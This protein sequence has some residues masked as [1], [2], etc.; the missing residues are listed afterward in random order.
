M[1]YLKD[2]SLYKKQNVFYTDPISGKFNN[3]R[4]ITMFSVALSFFVLPWISWKGKQAFIF[5]IVYN[6]LYILNLT[7]WPQ[8]FILLAIFLILIVLLLFTVT[9]Y[10]G[11]VWCGF[12]CPQSIWIKMSSFITRLL[13][14][15]RNKRKKMN[16]NPLLIKN[17]FIK[18]IKHILLIFL[19]LLTALTFVGYFVPFYQLLKIFFSINFLSWSFLWIIFFTLLSY[20]NIEWFKEQFCF[21]I[22]PYARL[23]SVMFDENTLIIAY[24]EYRGEKR[25]PRP[26][27]SDVSNLNLGD[28][29]DCKQCVNCCPVGID[30]RNGFQI[31]CISCAACIDACDAVMIKM[32]YSRGLIRYMTEND[33]NKNSNKSISIARLL[34]YSIILIILI[35]LF[36]YMLITRSLVQF[37]VVRNQTQLFNITK[38][39]FVENTYV[40]KITN[41][42]QKQSIYKINIKDDR[43]QYI[44]V[45]RLILD[46]EST[47]SLDIKVIL[48][49]KSL[50]SKFIEILF[51][52]SCDEISSNMVKSS[53]FI[54]PVSL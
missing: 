27:K 19:S 6:R 7:F 18:I 25:G 35:L 52:I 47:I 4:L 44:G 15:K 33:L 32:N 9:V 36:V 11:R 10:A 31:E 50:K 45:D 3:I 40:L 28:C 22:C 13:E 43:F 24:D 41:K 54:M 34:S 20:F 49:D 46:S 17:I 8:D 48:L 5:D 51:Y 16:Q 53:Q 21:L 39:N 29:I 14:G 12:L 2:Q 26:K 1:K 42:T 23:Q 38:E 37:N 30:I